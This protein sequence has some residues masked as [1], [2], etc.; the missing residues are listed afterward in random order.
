MARSLEG[1]REV[2]D[3]DKHKR[4]LADDTKEALGNSLEYIWAAAEAAS[5]CRC[6]KLSWT[7][8]LIGLL[9]LHDTANL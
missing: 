6:R 1:C 5:G 8:V 7:I 4:N 9:L 2:Q 3:V